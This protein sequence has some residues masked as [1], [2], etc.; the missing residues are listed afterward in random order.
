MKDNNDISNEKTGSGPENMFASLKEERES[1][2]LSLSDIFTATRISLNNLGALEDGDFKSLPPPVYTRSFITQYTRTI[3]I[4][5]KP[6]L[7]VYESY[8][9]QASK[10][11]KITE[12]QK[13]WPEE[14]R[15]YWL[16]YGGLAV[17]I[18][19]GLIVLA[20]FLYDHNDKPLVTASLPVSKGVA[21]PVATKTEVPSAVSQ[22]ETATASAPGKMV[23]SLP[24]QGL[25]NIYRLIIEANELTWIRMQIDKK[26]VSE[27]LLRPGE[28]IEREAS[29]GFILDIGN[30]GGVSISF[31]GKALSALGKHGEVVHIRLPD[32][33][34]GGNT[35]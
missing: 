32:Q 33:E 4:D 11:V 35:R 21:P 6:L 10:P 28:K 20:L 9:A 24:E 26:E 8:L 19:A 3:G 30:A 1:R 5:E 27:I 34:Q 17:A 18:A 14:N 23:L 2:G 16:L 29:Q 22:T 15:R 7:D 31:Q 25:K 13:P 12:V